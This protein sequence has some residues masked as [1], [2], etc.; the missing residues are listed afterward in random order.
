M[1]P[2]PFPLEIYSQIMGQ[3]IR[4]QDLSSFALCCRAFRNEAQR[5]LFRHPSDL[6]FVQQAEFFD[7]IITSPLRLGLIVKS[8]TIRRLAGD[9]SDFE[10]AREAAAAALPSM[11]NLRILMIHNATCI[12]MAILLDCSFQ[13]DTLAFRGDHNR[14]IELLFFEFLRKQPSLRHLTIHGRT[15]DTIQTHILRNDRAW[16]P[17]LM[18]LGVEEGLMDMFLAKHRPIQH[19][20]WF[21]SP[22]GELIALPSSSHLSS[23]EYFSC[24]IQPNIS[25]SHVLRK[26]TSL[27]LLDMYLSYMRDG[28]LLQK[29]CAPGALINCEIDL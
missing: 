22:P 6:T 2:P 8:Y 9:E 16:C 24:T 12:D 7:A 13:L 14:E 18:S 20:H 25:F 19:L 28:E 15:T 1:T 5:A 27:V 10:Q 3:V 4:R 23:V 21:N 26:M 17:N 11:R 29:V